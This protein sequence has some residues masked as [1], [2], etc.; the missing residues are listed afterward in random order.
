MTFVAVFP[1]K[2][3]LFG[4]RYITLSFTESALA[5]DLGIVRSITR[6][7]SETAL[8]SEATSKTVSREFT[9][10]ATASEVMTKTPVKGFSETATASEIEFLK[11]IAK[12]FSETALASE[13]VAKAYSKTISELATASESVSKSIT[14][15][16]RELVILAEAVSKLLEKEFT[17]T[18]S[19][20]EYW[21]HV[22]PFIDIRDVIH[23]LIKAVEVEG[24]CDDP[25]IVHLLKEIVRKLGGV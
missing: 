13:S 19:A 14:K 9:E 25:Y 10:T 22:Y 21:S 5:N 1:T 11:T 15:E 18:A 7:I 24:I 6:N 4:K 16:M 8:A 3:P 12:V 17:E 23:R 20:Y 2:F